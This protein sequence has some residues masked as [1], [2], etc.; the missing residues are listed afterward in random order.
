MRHRWVNDWYGIHIRLS[1]AIS[2]GMNLQ[3]NC[4]WHGIPHTGAVMRK[5]YP[6]KDVTMISWWRH[7]MET[8]SALLSLCEGNSPATREFPSQRPVTSGLD[9]FFDL[10]LNKRLGKQSRRWWFKTLSHP[11]WRHCIATWIFRCRVTLW[12]GREQ[13][14]L[15]NDREIWSVEPRHGKRPCCEF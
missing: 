2:P 11:L 5:T 3:L 1:K 6:H 4:F 7:Q 12:S 14:Y 10:R 15:G 9:V 13:R 8:F